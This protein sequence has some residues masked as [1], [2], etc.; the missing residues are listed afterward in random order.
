MAFLIHFSAFLIFPCFS[1]SLPSWKIASELSGSNLKNQKTYIVKKK[2][3]NSPI[4]HGSMVLM[5]RLYY[6]NDIFRLKLF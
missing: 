1:S 5:Q 3:G 2:R 4:P 6:P